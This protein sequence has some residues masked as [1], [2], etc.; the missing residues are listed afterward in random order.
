MSKIQDPQ[1]SS[2]LSESKP[3][4]DL[5]DILVVEPHSH[6]DSLPDEELNHRAGS[7]LN[8]PTFQNGLYRQNLVEEPSCCAK[9]CCCCVVGKCKDRSGLS[10]KRDSDCGV[11]VIVIGLAIF[12][13]A[14]YFSRTNVYSIVQR[15]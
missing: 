12:S 8:T 10:R 4:L 14:Y 11:L 2:K 1:H 6:A 3:S 5:N 13:L 9:F 7:V 15:Q